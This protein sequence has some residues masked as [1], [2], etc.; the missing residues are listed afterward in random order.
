MNAT[1]SEYHEGDPTMAL[2]TLTKTAAPSLARWQPTL[3]GE[4]GFLAAIEIGQLGAEIGDAVDA[5]LFA[6]D[7]RASLE[8]ALDESLLR[9]QLA[10]T[11]ILRGS[12]HPLAA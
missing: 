4:G 12:P 5:A 9:D 10:R 6:F 3:L 2:Q 7:L 8:E 1:T 11:P